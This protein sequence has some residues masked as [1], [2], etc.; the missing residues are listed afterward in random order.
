MPVMSLHQH[1]RR[2]WFP[3]AT[4]IESREERLLRDTEKYPSTY[5]ILS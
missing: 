5:I 1:R 2:E 4:N 3:L